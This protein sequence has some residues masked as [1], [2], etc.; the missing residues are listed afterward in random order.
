MSL[1]AMPEEYGDP[2]LVSR[3]RKGLGIV[4]FFFLYKKEIKILMV[5]FFLLSIFYGD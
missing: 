1:L 3:A 2:R 4:F 5:A